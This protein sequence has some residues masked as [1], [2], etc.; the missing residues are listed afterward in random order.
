[1]FVSIRWTARQPTEPF[2]TLDLASSLITGRI[3]GRSRR[4][5]HPLIPPGE[6]LQF[7]FDLGR[8]RD[9]PLISGLRPPGLRF[10]VFRPGFLPNMEHVLAE[11]DIPPLQMGEFRRAHPGVQQHQKRRSAGR[12]RSV[13]HNPLSFVSRPTRLRFWFRLGDLVTSERINADGSDVA[14]RCGPSVSPW[15][16][17][18]IAGEYAVREFCDR[19]S[20]FKDNPIEGIVMP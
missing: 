14:R 20:S 17:G 15:W 16:S 19:A 7:R 18:G 12:S 1:L 9:G 5:E 2:P 13:C 11:I 6:L 4:E 8:H 3:L 10:P